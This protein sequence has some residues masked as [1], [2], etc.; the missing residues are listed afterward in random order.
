M[1]ILNT[2]MSGAT[3]NS[4]ALD[5]VFLSL[6][7]AFVLGQL[8]AWAYVYT[9]SGLSYSRSFV[10]S[11][12]LLTIIICMSMM[13]IGT[14]IVIA[15]G[16][17]GALS[18][19]RFRNILKDTRDTAFIF[20][21]LVIGMATGTGRFSIAILGTCVFCALLLYLHWSDFG[22]LHTG[23]GFLRFHVSP[24]EGSQEAPI[25]ILARYC[26]S[27]HLVSQRFHETGHGELAYR[28]IMRDPG[29]ADDF[30]NELRGAAGI[31]QVTFVSHEER[32]QV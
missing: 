12:I 29:R 31:S 16:L 24:G 23:D 14:S 4:T 6:L 10:Q 13:V 18:V 27:S 25:P 5:Q 3:A 9:H 2:L 17:I 26:R 7:L 22:H 28:L 8:A 15:F 20:F 1:D 32:V 30:V 11:I 19:I 21:A